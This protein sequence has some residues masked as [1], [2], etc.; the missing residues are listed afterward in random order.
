MKATEVHLSDL[1]EI[2]YRYFTVDIPELQHLSVMIIEFSGECGYGS[3]SNA[4]ASFM[5]G[6]MAAGFRAWNPSCCIL[7]LRKLKYEWGDMMCS[8]FNPPHELISLTEEE[9]EYPFAVVISD[10]NREGLTSLVSQEMSEDPAT[11]LFD[12]IEAAAQRV[13]EI[14]HKTYRIA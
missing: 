13:V 2:Q 7:D 9:V 1:S 11:I 5:E 3:S 6:M 10:L 4:D 12:S 14:A 8:L